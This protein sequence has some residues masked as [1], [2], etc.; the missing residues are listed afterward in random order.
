MK[1]VFSFYDYSLDLKRINLVSICLIYKKLYANI[2]TQYI[3]ISFINY[4]V[5][6]ITKTLIERLT[7]LMDFVIAH[8][9]T[10]YIKDRYILDKLNHF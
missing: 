7:P 2:I 6:I 1:F 5:K 8:T 10:A 9:Q 4:S 3:S